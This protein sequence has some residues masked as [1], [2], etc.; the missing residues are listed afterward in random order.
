MSVRR[1]H[2]ARKAHICDGCDY[3]QESRTLWSAHIQPGDVYLSLVIFPGEEPS[4]RM[5]SAG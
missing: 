1:R 5:G 3:P 2:R 4:G